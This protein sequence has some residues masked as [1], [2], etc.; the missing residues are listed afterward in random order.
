MREVAILSWA[1]I[2]PFRPS[3]GPGAPFEAYKEHL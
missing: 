2:R 3:G 1:S